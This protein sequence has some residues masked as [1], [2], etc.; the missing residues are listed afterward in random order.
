MVQCEFAVRH[1]RPR[2]VLALAALLALGGCSWVPNAVNP[3]AWYRDVTGAAKNDALDRNQPNQKAFDAGGTKPYPN[4]ATVPGAPDTALSTIDRDKLKESLVADRANAE[5][6]AEHLKAGMSTPALAPTPPPPA[7]MRVAPGTAAYQLPP[8]KE[9]V[10]PVT[11]TATLAP[12]TPARAAA[13][14]PNTAIAAIA[15]ASGSTALTAAEKARISFI[16][17]LQKRDGG[18]LRVVG[19]APPA[20]SSETV[21]KRLTSFDLALARAKAVASALGTAGVPARS[22]TVE[23][24]PTRAD[25]ETAANAEVFLNH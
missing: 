13:P 16:A 15:F 19:H 20:G 14:P 23:A 4:L 1:T 3:I 9:P 24:A 17:A 25:D 10:A 12:P 18:T 5:Y 21:E 2:A 11:K 6:T 22:I 8:R 7:A